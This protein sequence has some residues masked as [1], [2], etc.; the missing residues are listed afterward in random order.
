MIAVPLWLTRLLAWILHLAGAQTLAGFLDIYHQE[1]RSEESLITEA[2]ILCLVLYGIALFKFLEKPAGRRVAYSLVSTWLRFKIF[3]TRL[4]KRLTSCASM[5]ILLV[6]LARKV[7]DCAV[8][9]ARK[10]RCNSSTILR[11]RLAQQLDKMETLCIAIRTAERVRDRALDNVGRIR[12][13]SSLESYPT[14]LLQGAY[15]A[16]AAPLQTSW[17]GFTRLSPLEMLLLIG[18]IDMAKSAV[19]CGASF[20]SYDHGLT[21]REEKCLTRL[22]TYIRNDLAKRVGLDPGFR[23]AQADER[24]ILLHLAI[25][26]AWSFDIL[27]GRT[28]TAFTVL[29]YSWI[30]INASP[31]HD[32]HNNLN[33]VAL[34]ESIRDLRMSPFRFVRY[35]NLGIATFESFQAVEQLGKLE[36]Q[37]FEF[38]IEA[39]K[40]RR[41]LKDKLCEER[42]K[43]R[44]GAGSLRRSN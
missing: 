33:G 8:R 22:L 18:C 35:D 42:E 6:D 10:L 14:E 5:E 11:F 4:V 25:V 39:V 40:A 12:R 44:T 36:T 41:D 34:F 21:P 30:L 24:L 3:A 27:S 7:G 15:M 38:I 26:V 9:I 19:T 29:C 2:V 1:N 32:L 16:T 13:S 31:R 37:L 43:A 20:D 28:V 17:Q 23:V